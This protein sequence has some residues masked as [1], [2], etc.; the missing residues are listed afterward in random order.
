MLR[1][2]LLDFVLYQLSKRTSLEI[3]YTPFFCLDITEWS[4][5]PLSEN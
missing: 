2:F 5:I 4:P 1:I 3:P